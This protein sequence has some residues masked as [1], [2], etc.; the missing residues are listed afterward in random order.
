[1]FI[2]MLTLI[3]L[4]FTGTF[5]FPMD[6]SLLYLITI[7][8]KEISGYDSNDSTSANVKIP[9]YFDW[10]RWGV[11]MRGLLP[12]GYAYAGIGTGGVCLCDMG[13]LGGDWYR[14]GMLM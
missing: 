3:V 14:R 8:M 11:L 10:F 9:N 1:M 6:M 5:N 13:C 12:V 2:L 7:L 4:P